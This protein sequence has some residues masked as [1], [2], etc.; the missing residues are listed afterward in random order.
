MK[1]H[2]IIFL[3]VAIAAVSGTALAEAEYRLTSCVCV[4]ENGFAVAFE[5]ARKEKRRLSF[6]PKGL[7]FGGN[8]KGVVPLKGVKELRLEPVLQV[9]YA[10]TEHSP[11]NFGALSPECQQLIRSVAAP[12]VQAQ[13]G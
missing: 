5:S 9:V 13:G 1:L 10:G 11:L 2:R 3:F 6:S 8:V 7:E 4:G 12:L